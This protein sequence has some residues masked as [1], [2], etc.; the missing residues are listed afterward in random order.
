VLFAQWREKRDNTSYVAK[1]LFV[2][3]NQ[4]FLMQK[5]WRE[6]RED[7]KEKVWRMCRN[8]RK[9]SEENGGTGKLTIP[10]QAAR[11]CC[12]SQ[13]AHLTPASCVFSI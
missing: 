6:K 2:S 9:C 7:F 1:C 4:L 8:H 3:E 13:N 12:Q 11:F 10:C 5:K